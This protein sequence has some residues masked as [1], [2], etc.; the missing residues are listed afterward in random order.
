M[1]LIS[2]PGYPNY[3][4]DINGNIYTDRNGRIKKR[5][6]KIDKDGYKT[7]GLW[8]NGKQHCYS[9]HRLVA[10]TFIPNPNNLPQIDHIDRNK[11]NNNVYNLRWVDAK[12]NA[13]NKPY[14]SRVIQARINGAVTSKPVSQYTIDG[15]KIAS[16]KSIAE[17]KRITNITH[18]SDACRNKVC[19]D[20]EGYKHTTRTAG[21]YI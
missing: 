2:I 8:K 13:N 18:I 14:S 21:G 16:Y 20:K 19:T 1:E 11:L 5:T 12:T 15:E 17:A 3:K 7:I 4:I 6:C 10:L 9:I